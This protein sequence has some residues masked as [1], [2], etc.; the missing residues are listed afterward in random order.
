[1]LAA[2]FNNE[3]DD[4]DLKKAQF[5]IQPPTVNQEEYVQALLADATNA[6]N[7]GVEAVAITLN[8]ADFEG[9]QELKP[10]ISR[11]IVLGALEQQKPV[12]A[13]IR[14]ALSNGQ[15]GVSGVTVQDGRMKM[16]G[17]WIF[18]S[19]MLQGE[20]GGFSVSSSSETWLEDTI[21]ASVYLLPAR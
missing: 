2:T 5:A 14:A 20:G 9:R 17:L 13:I 10:V 3:Y 4:I 19:G 12:R 1:M 8:V 18:G 11:A 16:N 15:R 7:V 6:E 21:R